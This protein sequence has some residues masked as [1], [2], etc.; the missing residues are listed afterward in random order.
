MA[1]PN[2]DIT[3]VHKL[4]IEAL[5]SV[6]PY[7]L[8]DQRMVRRV[9]AK[10]PVGS[11]IFR[12]C[13]HVL[14]Y[15]KNVSEEDSGSVF[16]GWA[17]ES[18]ARALYEQPL[19][20]GRLRRG[21]DGDGELEI[22]SNDSGAR[23]VEAQMNIT[24][25]E[26]LELKEKEE[27]EAQLVSWNDI[28]E[29]NPQFSPL[30]YVQVTN[31]RCGGYSVGIS[32]SLLLADILVKDNFLNN[33]ANMHNNILSNNNE[34]TKPIFYLPNLKTNG[35]S[36]ANIISHSPRNDCGQTMH[37]KVTTNENANLDYGEFCKSLALLCIEKTE[38]RLGSTM[39]SEF[40]LFVKENSEVIEIAKY[41]KHGH[42][43]PQLS[44][45]TQVTCAGWDEYL[46]AN[47][48][49]FRDGNKPMHVSYWIGSIFD[50]L[51]IAIPPFN[52]ATLGVNILVTIPNENKL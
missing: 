11:G 39:V 24:L 32:C 2:N 46:G 31:F 17:K 43:N 52:Q 13:L 49:P 16:A 34:S 37:F 27:A 50:G 1:S 45:K 36:P 47:E 26:F 48:I 21:E 9:F 28:D 12:G 10:D 20:S 23:L 33:W 22:V 38:R 29:H 18:L 7:K 40:S 4:K 42:V 19:L 51:V 8:I 14:L 15:Y 44:L 41:S 3:I 5:L 30:F 6:T 25:S 35:Y